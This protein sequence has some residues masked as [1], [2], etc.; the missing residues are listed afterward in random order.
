MFNSIFEQAKERMRELEDRI[1]EIIELKEQKE[2]RMKKNKQTLRHLWLQ[3]SRPIYT[4]RDSQ[5]EKR[6]W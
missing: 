5:E 2:K 4:L 1:I 6:E 3:S